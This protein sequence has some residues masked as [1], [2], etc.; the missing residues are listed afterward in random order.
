MTCWLNRYFTDIITQTNTDRSLVEIN[1]SIV[2]EDSK[3][4]ALKISYDLYIPSKTLTIQFTVCE[5]CE[6]LNSNNVNG[7][8]RNSSFMTNE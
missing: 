1:V 6:S 7:Y 4:I 2:T 5:Y 3:S 8:H